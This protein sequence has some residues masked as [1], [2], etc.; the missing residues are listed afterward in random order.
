MSKIEKIKKSLDEMES[1]IS[2][3]HS[4]QTDDKISLAAQKGHMLLDRAEQGA[5]GLAHKMHEKRE[6]YRKMD[7]NKKDK[8]WEYFIAAMVALIAIMTLK[9]INNRSH[10][11]D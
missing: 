9:K 8:M 6:M 10:K 4:K 2:D 3:S 7:K 5:H 1:F 11:D